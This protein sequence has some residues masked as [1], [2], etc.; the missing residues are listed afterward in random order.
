MTDIVVEK[1][2]SVSMRNGLVRIETQATGADGQDRSTG[3]IVIPA[4]Q[5]A[6]VVNALQSAGQQLQQKIA[7]AQKEQQGTDG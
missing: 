6:P 7:E 2:G 3:E 4:S 1:L 5:F